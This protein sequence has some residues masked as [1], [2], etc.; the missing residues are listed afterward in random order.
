MTKDNGQLT[1]NDYT[2]KEEIA[3]RQLQELTA[4]IQK[5]NETMRKPCLPTASIR[6]YKKCWND[7]L[8]TVERI[9]GEKIDFGYYYFS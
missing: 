2:T 1:D 3:Y 6:K 9:T 8:R 5:G 7:L 4:V